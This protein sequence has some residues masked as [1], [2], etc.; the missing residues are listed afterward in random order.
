[1][2]VE[3]VHLVGALG[4]PRRG[5]PTSLTLVE[6]PVKEELLGGLLD[7]PTVVGIPGEW[8]LAAPVGHH[9]KGETTAYEGREVPD[10]HPGLAGVGGGGIVDADD[11]ATH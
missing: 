10:H 7:Q 1:M 4:E 5:S 2:R 9:A 6:V 8:P 11:K 3:A